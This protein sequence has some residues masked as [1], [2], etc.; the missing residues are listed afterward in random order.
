M[1]DLLINM[2][3]GLNCYE[4]LEARNQ[5]LLDEATEYIKKMEG[6]VI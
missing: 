2:K 1:R 6:G 4:V 3:T 5:R